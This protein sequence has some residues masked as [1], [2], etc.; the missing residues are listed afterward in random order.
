MEWSEDCTVRGKTLGKRP[1]QVRLCV[2]AGGAAQVN[3]G[4][5]FRKYAGFGINGV[6]DGAGAVPETERNGRA[7]R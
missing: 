6:Y 4:N 2:F 1:S 5:A 7:A 3:I